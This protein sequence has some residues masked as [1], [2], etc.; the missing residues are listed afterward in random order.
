MLP[1]TPPPV[2]QNLPVP[3]LD[4]VAHLLAAY[5]WGHP[6]PPAPDLKGPEALR[7]RWLLAAAT[8]QPGALPADPFPPGPDHREAEA[9]RGLLRPEPKDLARGLAR[10][11]LHLPG[12]ALALW[13]WGQIQ[14]RRGVFT[15]ALR[16]AW[17]DRL[18]AEGPPLTRGYAL[19]HALCWA[20]AE[21]DETRFARLKATRQPL[22]EDT[23]AL[24]Q[25]LFGLLGGPSPVLRLWPLPG[26]GYQDLRLDQ[27]GARRIWI[28]PAPR[29]PLPA[30]PGDVAWIIPSAAGSQDPGSATLGAPSLDEGRALAQRL[31]AAGRRAFFAPSRADM[32]QTGL[33]W[34]PALV[35]LDHQGFLKDIR[36]GDAAPE[37]P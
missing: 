9:L 5:D 10:L 26:L 6:L 30:L 7:Y 17:E 27:L 19:R 31:A 15:P 25:R 14:V 29:G 33:V 18:L 37:Q 12:T 13:R 1:P 35:V 36:M 11:P 4:A 24:F 23:F 34:F 21:H 8:F 20:L 32:E 2:V 3:H 16:R 22:A 28:C